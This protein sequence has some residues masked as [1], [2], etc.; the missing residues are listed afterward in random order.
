MTTSQSNTDLHQSNEVNSIAYWLAVIVVFALLIRAWDLNGT[1]FT[2]DEVSEINSAHASLQ[3]I[4][5]DEDD[6]RFPPFYRFVLS[7]CVKAT[8]T[9]LTLRWVSVVCGVLAVVVVWMIGKEIAGTR[10]GLWSAFLLAVSPFHIH[11]SREGRAYGF[12]FLFCCI[13]MWAA[14]RLSRTSKFKDWLCLGFASL[15][16]LY[17]HYY[18]VPFLAVL[19]LSAL[20]VTRTHGTWRYAWIVLAGCALFSIPVALILLDATENMPAGSLVAWFDI[21]AWAY[22]FLIQVS[23]F[24]FGPSMRELRSISAAE[25]IR[26]FLPWVAATGVALATLSYFAYL[27]LKDSKWLGML[28]VFLVAMVPLVGYAGNLFGVGCTY[29]YV[30]WIALPYVLWL[31]AGAAQLSHRKLVLPAVCLLLVL[32]GIA[33]YNRHNDPRYAKEDFRAVAQYLEDHEYGNMPVLVANP[34]I[35]TALDYYLDDEWEISSFSIFVEYKEGRK[36]SLEEFVDSHSPGSRL[37][38]LSE[39]LPYDDSRLETRNE[40]RDRFQAELIHELCMME[41]SVGRIPP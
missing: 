29:R 11:F 3:S 7:S 9:D 23:G 41:I 21:E 24:T 18:A 16:A 31:G 35:A 27:T 32:N 36:R 39:W 5:M 25:G 37:W 38:I 14:V 2:S 12:Y 17:C 4:I 20:W 30:I 19:W 1:G 10:V 22:T 26:M 13:A 15:L 33:V 34:Y 6:D 28:A 8:G 40:V